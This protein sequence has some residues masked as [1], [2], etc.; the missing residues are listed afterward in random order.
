MLLFGEGCVIRGP[1]PPGASVLCRVQEGQERTK[2]GS[3][4]RGRVCVEADLITG[5]EA[6]ATEA[7]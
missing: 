6:H 3:N 1:G 4:T 5:A 2:L 7:A